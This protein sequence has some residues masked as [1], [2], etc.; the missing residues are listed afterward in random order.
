M[1]IG[2]DGDGSNGVG[3]YDDA[4]TLQIRK[5]TT[6]VSN[7][8]TISPTRRSLAHNMHCVDPSI[9]TALSTHILVLLNDLSLDEHAKSFTCNPSCDAPSACN[10]RLT[11][12]SG[13][14]VYDDANTL[15]IR[16][17]TM[18]VSNAIT[19]CPTSPKLRC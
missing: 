2:I 7:A 19:I 18:R 3:V 9:L 14:G 1:S 17:R 8:I 12:L 10:N 6:R 16:K 11:I 5:T 15:Q 13:V 4:N